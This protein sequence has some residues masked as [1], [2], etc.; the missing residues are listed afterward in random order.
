[1]CWGR[2]YD[3]QCTMHADRERENQRDNDRY[4]DRESQADGEDIINID[5]NLYFDENNKH[6]DKR[7]L[8]DAYNEYVNDLK[9]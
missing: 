2:C 5:Q 6:E 8:T 7:S 3:G 4:T 9:K 1:M